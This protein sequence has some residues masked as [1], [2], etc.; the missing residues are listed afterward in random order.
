LCAIRL[1]LDTTFRGHLNVVVSAPDTLLNAESSC[2]TSKVHCLLVKKIGI[3]AQ[4]VVLKIY[5]DSFPAMSHAIA[6]AEI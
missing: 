1:P 2:V 5:D 6:A 4:R 3:F